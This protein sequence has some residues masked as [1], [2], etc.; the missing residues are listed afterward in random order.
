[1][2]TIGLTLHTLV[3]K[4]DPDS[5]DYIFAI[6]LLINTGD[7]LSMYI[8]FVNAGNLHSTLKHLIRGQCR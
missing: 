6:L 1:M 3:V 5:A 2:V 7:Y 8:L 4:L